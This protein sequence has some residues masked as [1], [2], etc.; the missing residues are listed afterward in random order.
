MCN[1]YNIIGLYDIGH[2]MYI[3]DLGCAS[4]VN[5]SA[6]TV[7]LQVVN[8]TSVRRLQAFLDT[9]ERLHEAV[10]RLQNLAVQA[11]EG[12]GILL[13]TMIWCLKTS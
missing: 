9:A 7:T 13:K 2:A 5:E 1:L 8:T 11:G 12:L 3:K 4:E 6:V 10:R